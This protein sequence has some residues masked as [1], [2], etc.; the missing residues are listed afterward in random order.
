MISVSAEELAARAAVLA[1]EEKVA[2]DSD[3]VEAD[4]V[5]CDGVQGDTGDN[6][7]IGPSGHGDSAR[8]PAAATPDTR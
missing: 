8:G 1:P 3:Y 5:A 7:I 6:G 4:S 2:D